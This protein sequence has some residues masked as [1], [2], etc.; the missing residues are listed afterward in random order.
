MLELG[1]HE[2]VERIVVDR[3]RD[4][5]LFGV[6]TPD[7]QVPSMRVPV[8]VQVT[9]MCGDEPRTLAEGAR[10]T[11]AP[12]VR[13]QLCEGG[14]RL[15][16]A[17]DEDAATIEAI[18]CEVAGTDFGLVVLAPSEASETK[19]LVLHPMDGAA[20]RV[21]ASGI[22]HASWRMGRA[23]WAAGDEAIALDTGGRVLALDLVGGEPRVV[24]EAIADLVV[25]GD[26]R[27]LL[28]QSG[29]DPMASSAVCVIDRDTGER[30]EIADATLGANPLPFFG[31]WLALREAV[32]V[33]HRIFALE[34]GHELPLPPGTSFVRDLPDGRAWL[35]AMDAPHGHADER[36]W[37][38]AT[39]ELVA[40]YAGPGIPSFADDGLEIFAPSDDAGIQRGTVLSIPWTGGAPV[41]LA[42]DVGWQRVRVG[43]DGRFVSVRQM[44]DDPP[45]G[46]LYLHDPLDP[47]PVRIAGGVL[48]PSIHLARHD[49]FDGDLVWIAEE[50]GGRTLWRIRVP[51]REE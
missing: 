37:D 29:G 9:D 32:G 42:E 24:A 31:P 5:V 43:S 38:P 36:A 41:T 12:G 48:A 8:A 16:A 33:P 27:F 40:L 6:V 1:A 13:P 49:P 23:W 28:T 14:A 47:D 45:L 3:D 34:G 17:S 46:D 22:V 4:E 50:G 18:D 15:R 11:T 19:E 51:P 30:H 20:P 2:E 35:H 44:Q 21:L 10:L 7:A 25:S 26:G 39:G